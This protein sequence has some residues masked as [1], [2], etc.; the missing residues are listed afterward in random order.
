MS[1]LSTSERGSGYTGSSTAPT[2]GAKPA[3]VWE[4]FIDIFYAPSTVFARRMNSGFGIP[5]L[6]VTLL[7]GAIFL[8]NSGVLQPIMDAEFTRS[9]AIAQRQNP[10][11]TPEMMEKWRAIGETLAKIGAFVFMPVGIFLTGLALWLVGKLFDSKQTAAAAVMVAAYAFVPRIVEAVLSGVQGL[12]LDPATLNGR[13]RLSLG[14]GRFLDPDT[15]SPVLLA[16]VGRLDVVTIWVTVLLAIGLA[17][18]GKIPRTRA[19]AAAAIVWLVGAL[20]ALLGALRNS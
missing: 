7:V 14:V 1:D 20:P 5:M 10:N 4:D 6:V 9:M 2:P 19:A 11:V 8:A 16:L 17:V 3:S 18:T 12:L 15:A 13:F